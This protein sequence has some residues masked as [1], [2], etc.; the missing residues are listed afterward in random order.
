VLDHLGS[1]SVITDQSGAVVTGG[2]LS[3]DAWGKR[4]NADG[5]DAGPGRIV[6]RCDIEGGGAPVR[7]EHPLPHQRARAV[8]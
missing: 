8:D 7:P 3:Y 5:S 2:R 6:C 1:I 4:R